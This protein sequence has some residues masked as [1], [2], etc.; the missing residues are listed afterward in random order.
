MQ[1]HTFED[2]LTAKYI[3]L[4]SHKNMSWNSHIINIVNKANRTRAFFRKTNAD[5][6]KKPKIWPTN[7]YSD[8]WIS[9]VGV[10]GTNSQQAT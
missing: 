1:K 10:Y 9:T 6:Q 5:A 2:A 7:P 8:H 3:G 4:T